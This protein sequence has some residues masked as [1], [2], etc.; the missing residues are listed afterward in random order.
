MEGADVEE[1]KE[2]GGPTYF[3][4]ALVNNVFIH[5]KKG[6][7]GVKPAMVYF[8]GGGAV[9]GDANCYEPLMNRIAMDSD[10][11]VFGCNYGL[12][13]ERKAPG[14]IHDAY[15]ILKDILAN[16]QKHCIDPSQICIAGES[17]GGYIVAGLS[18]MLV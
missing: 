16:H 5:K 9:M 14:G 3:K 6:S 17:G 8:H 1:V 4:E 15:A 2:M 11:V 10:I 13:P 7:S 12:A 18:L